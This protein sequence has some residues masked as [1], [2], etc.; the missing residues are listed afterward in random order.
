MGK[1]QK[2]SDELQQESRRILVDMP[3]EVFQFASLARRKGVILKKIE[4]AYGYI[5]LQSCLDCAYKIQDLKDDSV[6]EEHGDVD[7][8]IS[9]GWAV[10]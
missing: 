10:S 9:A 1:N 5:T 7:S 6:I 2:W 4:G 8:L 3:A